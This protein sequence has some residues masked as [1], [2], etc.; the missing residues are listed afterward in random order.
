MCIRNSEWILLLGLWFGFAFFHFDPRGDLHNSAIWSVLPIWCTKV[1]CSVRKKRIA[2][3]ESRKPVGGKI[4]T[5]W[6]TCWGVF[7]P[8][9]PAVWKR[10][11][12]AEC[13]MGSINIFV[14]SPKQHWKHL[15]ISF[16]LF[17]NI[18][19]IRQHCIAVLTVFNLLRHS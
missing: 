8:G 14:K 7:R 17:R 16:W 3:L 5:R 2:N 4:K 15:L 13:F 9:Q 10:S 6:N 1:W 18:I 11:C 19:K 12:L